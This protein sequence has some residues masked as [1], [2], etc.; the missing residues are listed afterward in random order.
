MHTNTPA[1]A[2]ITK[3]TVYYLVHPKRPPLLALARDTATSVARV[4]AGTQSCSDV[5]TRSCETESL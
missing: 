5:C 4:Q 2:T 3:R 1:A